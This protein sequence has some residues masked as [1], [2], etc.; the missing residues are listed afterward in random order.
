MTS[1]T[2]NGEGPSSKPV[3]EILKEVDAKLDQ[4]E[5]QLGLPKLGPF[6]NESETTALFGM[7]TAE[8]R[9][10]SR[11]EQAE[12]VLLLQDYTIYL[13]RVMNREQSRITWCNQTIDRIIAPHVM[14]YRGY[15][16][17]ERRIQAIRDN[18][19]ASKVKRLL[20]EAE[21]RLNRIS[22]LPAK[23]DALARAFG[24]YLTRRNSNGYPS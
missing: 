10:M 13:Q 22:F 6:Q 16:V 14:G 1:Q 24:F 12:A 23:I 2:N 21:L 4:Y 20:N 5:Q 7:T 11:D 3:A 8:I 15:S 17:E 9:G 19:A 18:D